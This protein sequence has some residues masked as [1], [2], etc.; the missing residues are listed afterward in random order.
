MVHPVLYA[1]VSAAEAVAP[2]TSGLNPGKDGMGSQTPGGLP[3]AGAADLQACA[4]A[5]DPC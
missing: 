3:K 5:A 2:E 1:E 4:S